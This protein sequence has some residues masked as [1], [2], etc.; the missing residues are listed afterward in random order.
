MKKILLSV[1][2]LVLAVTCLS[3]FDSQNLMQTLYY[4]IV[5]ANIPTGASVSPSQVKF[6]ETTAPTTTCP[7]VVMIHYYCMIAV[8]QGQVTNTNF[9]HLRRLTTSSELVTISTRTSI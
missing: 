6:A 8:T 2:A 5:K 4:F 7:A 3:S 9:S 1:A